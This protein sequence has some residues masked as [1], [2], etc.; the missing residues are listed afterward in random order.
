[1]MGTKYNTVD[2]EITEWRSFS[3]HFFVDLDQ[4]HQKCM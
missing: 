3:D 2:L 4:I 1:M